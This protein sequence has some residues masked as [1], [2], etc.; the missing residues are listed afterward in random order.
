MHNLLVIKWQP[1]IDKESEISVH[2]SVEAAI[3]K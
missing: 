2:F 1:I 3:F